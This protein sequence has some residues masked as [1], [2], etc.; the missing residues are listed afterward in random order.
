FAMRT[1][2]RTFSHRRPAPPEE[3]AMRTPE[4]RPGVRRL[5][6]VAMGRDARNEA[7]DEIRLHLQLRVAQLMREG[8]SP[9]EARAEAERRFGS[10]DEERA[11]FE[12]AARR[13]EG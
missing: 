10:L 5:F 8:L 6:R 3:T 12:N 9:D 11:L 7:D 2:S 4:I 1:R 13:R